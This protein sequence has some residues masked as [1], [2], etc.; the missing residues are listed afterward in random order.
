[1]SKSSIDHYTDQLVEMWLEGKWGQVVRA[2][3]YNQDPE[4]RMDA[5]LS[6]A[7]AV[8][9]YEK[10]NRRLGH[11]NVQACEF[12]RRITATNSLWSEADPPL[13]ACGQKTKAECKACETHL[14][15]GRC[16][17]LDPYLDEPDEG[18]PRDQTWQIVEGHVNQDGTSVSVH[19]STTH[20]EWDSA[21]TD[22]LSFLQRYGVSR[23]GC[24]GVQV[25]VKL[26]GKEVKRFEK[27][28]PACGAGTVSA[29]FNATD[30]DT[31][32]WFDCGGS[33]F[34]DGTGGVDA[35]TARCH[36]TTAAGKEA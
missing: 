34:L 18:E 26:N 35:W 17:Y 13:A 24:S 32:V 10:L 15:S 19:V 21:C 1:M 27:T 12:Y 7:Y 8:A 25:T 16:E 9:V 6:A 31:R 28:C 2:I 36:N 20:S 33:M 4:I 14:G 3:R 23:V 22:V 11:G 29:D 30:G 5:E